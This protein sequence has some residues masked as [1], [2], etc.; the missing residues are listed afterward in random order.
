[1]VSQV[2][3]V[4]CSVVPEPHTT[5]ITFYKFPKAAEM[6]T[7]FKSWKNA[8]VDALSKE[9]PELLDDA[10]LCDTYICSRHFTVD[11]FAF[12]Q[13]KLGL[14]ENAVPSLVAKSDYEN[15]DAKQQST[16]ITKEYEPSS[17]ADN[18][19]TTFCNN[20]VTTSRHNL[21]SDY[22]ST[23]TSRVLTPTVYE[24]VTTSKRN[25]DDISSAQLGKPI[26]NGSDVSKKR[27]IDVQQKVDVFEQILKKMRCD[28][29]LTE[30]YLEKL[31]VK[32]LMISDLL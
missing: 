2:I 19:A 30:A 18:F 32:E 25:I 16:R 8:I 31:K 28:S 5:E 10:S 3:C 12:K 11:D 14:V 13:G 15:G 23:E 22:I 6:P 9:R 4:I 26:D 1:M 21:R 7:L 17:R 27:N 29:V 24:F 20:F